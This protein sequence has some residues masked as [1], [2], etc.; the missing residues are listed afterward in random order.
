MAAGA[1][2]APV[3]GLGA[4]CG[5][6]ARLAAGAV[7]AEFAVPSASGALAAWPLPAS[8]ATIAP[9]AATATSMIAPAIMPARKLISSS[10]ALM[11]AFRRYAP[12]PLT[13]SDD[14]D[15]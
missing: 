6:A 4:L 7:A 8:T 10:Q 3:P 14:T 9:T 2:R 15:E 12:V 5:C 13:T 11:P 1:E